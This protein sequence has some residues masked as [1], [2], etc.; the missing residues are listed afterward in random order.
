MG[1]YAE[2]AIDQGFD[3]LLNDSEDDDFDSDNVMYHRPSVF[4]RR[5]WRPNDFTPE[6]IWQCR[7]IE[8]FKI[9]R[10]TEKANLMAMH[11]RNNEGKWGV[12]GI[13][14]PK[15]QMCEYR[16]KTY[17]SN[18]FSGKIESAQAI[19]AFKEITGNEVDITTYEQNT[20]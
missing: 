16:G 18:W 1:E 15:S 6:Y 2:M 10:S 14:V 3:E 19:V 11:Y 13:W 12:M 4:K 17:I 20:K 5:D 7:E 9:L 8:K